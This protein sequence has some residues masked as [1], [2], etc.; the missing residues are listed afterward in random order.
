MWHVQEKVLDLSDELHLAKLRQVMQ[1]NT[2]E[3]EKQHII[4]EMEDLMV[5]VH[6]LILPLVFIF[7]I[8]FDS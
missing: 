6:C 7:L 5:P 3:E 8:D 2:F 4:N 1:E